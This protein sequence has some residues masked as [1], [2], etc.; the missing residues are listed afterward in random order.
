MHGIDEAVIN[1]VFG[2]HPEVPVGILGNALDRLSGM[3][4]QDLV[5]PLSHRN[6]FP[7]LNLYIR[8]YAPRPAGWLV[9]HYA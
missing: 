4:R 1:G 6:D 9:E 8:G 2:A 5:Q 7:R 3:L